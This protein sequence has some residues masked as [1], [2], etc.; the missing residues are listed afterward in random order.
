MAGCLAF[1]Y[2][3]ALTIFG[4][5]A[6]SAEPAPPFSLMSVK[7]AVA[8]FRKSTDFYV[9]YF[10]MTEGA[11]YNHAEQGLDWPGPG[12]GSTIVLVHD[13][14]GQIRL[15]RGTALLMFRVP[16]ARKIAPP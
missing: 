10:G 12:Q 2:F 9:K 13:D 14:S 15:A 3:A 5:G 7:I 11:R 16:D 8:D 6:V 4:A 1:A